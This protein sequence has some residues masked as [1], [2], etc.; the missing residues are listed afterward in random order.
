MSPSKQHRV[1]SA[2]WHDFD[3]AEEWYAKRSTDAA[4]RFSVAVDDALVSIARFPERWPRYLHQTRRY[5]LEEF[6]YSVVY[7]DRPNEVLILAVAHHKRRPGYWRRR[8]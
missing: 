3:E 2:A 8:I 6:P 7:I 4:H 5:L 1:H